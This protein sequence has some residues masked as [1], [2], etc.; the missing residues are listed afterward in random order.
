MTTH[1]RVAVIGG[2]VVGTS[3]LYHLAQRGW[4]DCILLERTEL[5]AGSTW[6]AAGLL[7]L[8]H[9]NYTLSQLNLRSIEL[10]GRLEAETGQ[11][12]S[13]HKCGQLRLATSHDRL[14]E[15]E[16]YLGLARTLGI[17]CGI[18]SQKRASE[19]WPLADMSDVLGALYHPQDGHIAPAD[20]TQALAK[21]AR[22]RGA[23]IHRHTE[24]TAMAQLASGEWHLTTPKG[25]FVV[26][27]V[28]TATGNFARQT[29]R[30]VGLS[31]PSIPVLHQYL[32]TD[33]I[34]AVR[35]RRAAN[36]PELPVLRD[37]KTKFYLRQEN[38]GLILG[39]YDSDPPAWA[40]DGVPADFGADLLPP[41]L[42]R[43]EHQV[44]GAVARCSA[45]GSTGI[46]S[47]VNGPIAHTPDGSPLIG[48]APGLRNY[49]LAEGFTAGILVA[50]G[51]G[52]Y[53]SEWITEGEAS[54]DMWPVDPR[55]YGRHVGRRH[56]VL[57]NNETY[58]HIF[59]LHYPNLEMPA[60]RPAKTSPCHD[61]L[62]RAGAVW[63]ETGGWERAQWFAPPAVGAETPTYRK[64]EA[65]SHIAAE[66]RTVREAVGLIELTSF[67]K[68][69][70]S[71]PD[72]EAFLDGYLANRL[73]TAGRVALSHALTPSGKVASEFTVTRLAPDKFYLV[74]PALMERHDEDLLR[75]AATPDLRLDI[76]NV[77]M[78]WG[79]FV[80][81]G[82]NAR[83]LLEKLTDLPLDNAAFPWF[84]WRDCELGWATDIRLLRVN[85]VG[86]LGYEIHH[87]I[88]FQHH[89]LD[90]I[91]A[92]GA[93]LGLRHVGFRALDSLRL[94]KSYRAIRAELTSE[95]TLDM[96]GLS[97]FARVDKGPFNGSVAVVAERERPAERRLVML[98]IDCSGSDIEPSGNHSIHSGDKIVGRTLSGGF[99]H[100]IGTGLALAYL[101]V[102][103][104]VVGEGLEIT[105]LGA[106]F[107]AKVIPD[108]PHDPENLRPRGL[109][110]A[111]GSVRAAMTKTD[112][113]AAE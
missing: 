105:I 11:P 52:H 22:G 6:H 9:P 19:L 49:W 67:S 29:G 66:C 8:Y 86:E 24:V 65:F 102:D 42:E 61:R 64:S 1:A 31:V 101:P 68:F 112:S 27:H 10:Y 100:F 45:F 25:D 93:D 55:R 14:D 37:D 96:A 35:Q 17:D 97:R 94:E 5:T 63:H 80:L 46:K 75:R 91:E 87:P 58:G 69:E 51:A 110:Q 113:V 43:V 50:G 74:G 21:G 79:C 77:T 108:S 90:Q 88:A 3:I 20:L 26:E 54:I 106:R 104:A 92:A 47:V 71:G 48:P 98:S 41:E 107:A 28:V 72:A 12:V 73:P 15:Y 23:K 36:Q 56:T 57:K 76:R 59:E 32:V 85:Y 95:D 40:V 39:P 33:A 70:I 89:L 111:H 81:A 18:V 83:Q 60:A 99:G 109:A 44:E 53:L 84:A 7:P 2:G 38:D 34:D 13:F 103:L 16:H 30:M 4:T 78:A 62:T 82:P